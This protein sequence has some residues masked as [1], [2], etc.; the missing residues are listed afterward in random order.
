MKA[1]IGSLF[2]SAALMLGAIF[3]PIAEAQ[4]QTFTNLYNFAGITQGAFPYANLIISGNTL[5]GTTEGDLNAD[6]ATAF[7]IHTDGTGFTNLSSFGISLAYGGLL[8]SGNTLYGTT[9]RGG[10]G[11]HGVIGPA[12]RVFAVNTNG[13]GFTNLYNF[14]TAYYFDNYT[15]SDGAEPYGGLILSSNTL[16]GTTFY[17]GI[18]GHGTVFAVNTDGTSF[19]NLHDFSGFSGSDGNYPYAG[20][21]LSGNTLYGTTEFSAGSLSGGTVFKV[22]TDGTGF[23]NVHS[24]AGSDGANL[25]GGLILSGNTLYGTTYS[26]GSSGNGTIFA[27]NTD[28]TGFTNLYVFTAFS[29]NTNNED[30]THPGCSLILSGNTL[31]GTA[32][33]GGSSNYGTAYAIKTDGTGFTNLH[34]FTNTDGANPQGGLVLSGNVLYGTTVKGGKGVGTIFSI[35]L[36]PQLA[37]SV[38]GTKIILT[39]PATA[40]GF[41]LQSTTDLVSPSWSA[42]S[43]GPVNVNGQNTV[44]NPI[45]GAQMFFRL[46]R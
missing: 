2:L 24:F 41:T 36:P 12:G 37:I 5:Y 43:P 15:N 6:Y 34:N 10:T 44:T 23:T 1:S 3:M 25:Q 11:D 28:G 17:G 26:G 39:W 38:L 19:T 21:I 40:A 18:A 8:L 13:T 46:S 31:Y 9:I 20:L 22:N 16:Y 29:S 7:A 45:S 27:V 42:V 14:S 35:S 4:A 30:G 32:S 33:G